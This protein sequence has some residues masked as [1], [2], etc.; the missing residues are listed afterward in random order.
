MNCSN[1]S[2]RSRKQIHLKNVEIYRQLS[3][4]TT[5]EGVSAPENNGLPLREIGLRDKCELIN[6][7]SR[8]K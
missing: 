8:K 4:R 1:N 7:K 6:L 3:E 5:E 2:K